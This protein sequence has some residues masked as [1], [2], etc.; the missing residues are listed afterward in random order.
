MLGYSS[1]MYSSTIPKR[2]YERKVFN[3]LEE[4]YL[5]SRIAFSHL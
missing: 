4:T 3:K 2:H 5:R 1:L